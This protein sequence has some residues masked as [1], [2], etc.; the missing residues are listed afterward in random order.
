[1]AGRPQ[2]SLS[3]RH[4][5]RLVRA[6]AA[7]NARP[8]QDRPRV[9]AADHRRSARAGRR[10]R[11]LLLAVRRKR[12]IRTSPRTRSP[13]GTC[14]D[15]PMPRASTSAAGR[16]TSGRST[17][18]SIRATAT[19]GRPSRD[20]SATTY[21]QASARGLAFARSDG[22]T[23]T[24]RD[25]VMHHFNAAIVTAITAARNRE[26]LMRNYLEYRRSAIAEGEKGPIREYLIVPGQDGSRAD[27]LA[28]NLATQ[29]IEVRRAEEPIKLAARTLPAGDLHRLERAADRAD[30]S[31]PARSQ[32][33]AVRRVHQKAGRAP[34]DALERSDLRHHGVEPADAV[35]RGAGHEPDADRREDERRAV[36]VRRADSRC[37]RSPRRRSAT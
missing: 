4:E 33:R 29:G 16:I 12:S 35:R 24:Y 5:P 13:A 28:R 26:M 18:P 6:V 32:N 36:A 10:Q 30:D 21:E 9:P 23:L 19:R 2:Q 22:D 8:H 11:L 20:R 25:G 31:Q 37:V 1:M 34:Q 27:Q 17:T 15:A 14:S 3:L 7:R